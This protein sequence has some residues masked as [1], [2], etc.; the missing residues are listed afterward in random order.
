MTQSHRVLETTDALAVELTT[1]LHASDLETLAR[2]FSAH[3]DIAH[4][5]LEDEHGARKSLMHAAVD[6]PGKHPHTARTIAWLADH[7]VPVDAPMQKDDGAS[8]E[9]P[10]HWA[11]S[12]DDVAAIDALLAAGADLEAPGAVFTDGTP[13]SDAVIF[14]QWLAARRLLEHGARTTLW[15][16]AGLGLMHRVDASL[17]GSSERERTAALWHACRSGHLSVAMRLAREGADWHLALGDGRTAWEVARAS[18]DD[19]LNAWLDE[20]ESQR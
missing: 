4:W 6:W 8:P 10:L 9:T 13:M 1:A 5:R 2:L 12:A 20:L 15:Q 16:A 19:E 18:G 17:P 11:A 3:P 14:Q 7:G